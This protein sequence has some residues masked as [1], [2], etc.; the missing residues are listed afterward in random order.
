M[1]N[2]RK[3]GWPRAT[4]V[5]ARV[6]QSPFTL[7]PETPARR[8]CRTDKA[9]MFTPLWSECQ[10]VWMTHEPI[11]GDLATLPPPT[12]LGGGAG[13]CG[14]ARTR[15]CMGA[16]VYRKPIFNSPEWCCGEAE[17][18]NRSGHGG[19]SQP[20]LQEFHSPL[21]GCISSFIGSYLTHERPTPPTSK[22]KALGWETGSTFCSR[23]PDRQLANRL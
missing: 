23:G 11:R 4:P 10:W 9:I 20:L 12:C 21:L 17:D 5:R 1:R 13:D 15:A 14:S 7:A 22:A 18:R 19:R 6:A 3:L 2:R 8:S 16:C